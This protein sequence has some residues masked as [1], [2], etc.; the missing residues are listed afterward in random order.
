MH[1]SV[2]VVYF[3]CLMVCTSDL[4]G[5]NSYDEC[6]RFHETSCLYIG[7]TFFLLNDLDETCNEKRKR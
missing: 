5:L 3:M 7:A 6:N 4:R 2:T 1:H